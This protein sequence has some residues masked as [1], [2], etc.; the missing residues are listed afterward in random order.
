MEME[1]ENITLREITQKDKDWVFLLT[2]RPRDLLKVELKE[3]GKSGKQGQKVGFD[4]SMLCACRETLVS[5]YTK[6]LRA[7]DNLKLTL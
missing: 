1:L 6:L 4:H 3:A 2:C 5:S 7:N